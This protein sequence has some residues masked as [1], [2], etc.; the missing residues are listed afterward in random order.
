MIICNVKVL[1][2]VHQYPPDHLG[3]TELYTQYL[4]QR[5]A[6]GGHIPSV[7]AP[8]ATGDPDPAPALEQGVRVYRQRVGSDSR[9]AVFLRT[10]WN[11]SAARFLERLLDQEQP[12]LA[13]IQHLMGL[14]A[15]L[16]EVLKKHRLP[17]V[18]TLHDYWTICANAQLL[19]N[20]DQTLCAGP[21]RFLNCARCVQ[22]R[23]GLPDLVV[24]R[25]GLVPLLARRNRL[26]G[27]LLN[28][29]EAIIA[30]SEFVRDETVRLGGPSERMVV[31]PH[32]IQL[33][34][35]MPAPG[36]PVTGELKVVYLGGITWQKGVH[37]L[38]E[39]ATGLPDG[40]QV[41]IYGDLSTQAEYSAALRRQARSA[42]VIFAG[43]L[44]R[45]EV[46]LALAAAD[47]VVVP[48]LWY[49]TS[50]LIAQEARAAGALVIASN[51]GALPERLTD[52]QDGLLFP[53]GDADVLRRL[54]REL[55]A[56]PER[57]GELQAAIT[58][59]RQIDD[60]VRDVEA[61]YRSVL[62]GANS[63]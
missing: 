51:L 16:V 18:L 42:K 28:G 20:Y 7:Y 24:A 5:Q 41:T 30:P 14:P 50:S 12:D 25:Y 34:D 19:T 15:K 17:Y 49:E 2:V 48:S 56:H 21:D 1:H 31:V 59:V 33:P 32:G 8:V 58:P 6:A 10:F 26:L 46:W 40:I 23:S 54:L 38:V 63:P 35:E 44:E 61:V 29:A 53:A 39:A 62:S 52:G 37:V 43:R 22:A 57:L 4:A 60:H 9:R 13:H 27:E 47:V 3:G 55:H 36:R 11:Q 45:D